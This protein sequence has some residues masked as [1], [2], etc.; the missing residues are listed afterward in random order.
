MQNTNLLKAKSSKLKAFTL[1]ELIIYIAMFAGA[2]IVLTSMLITILKVQ[3]REALGND[4][5]SQLTFVLENVNRLVR[6]SSLIEKVYEGNDLNAPCVNY[7]SVKLRMPKSSED[8]TIITSDED[9]IYLKRGST[10]PCAA[11][12]PNS[13]E[14]AI[15]NEKVVV[16]NLNFKQD[17]VQRGRSILNIDASLKFNSPD[18][19]FAIL[20]SIKSA[21]GRASAA[22]FDGSIVPIAVPP[23]TSDNQYDVG[24]AGNRWRDGFFG[25]NLIIGGISGV[26]IDEDTD[27][28]SGTSFYVPSTAGYFQFAKSGAGAPTATDCDQDNERGRLYIDTTNNRFYVCNGAT[29]NWDYAV[30]TN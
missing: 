15:T 14:C 6:E 9:A 3:N 28:P 17:V 10:G 26:G 11:T 19:K 18:P 5:S 21:V 29:R 27:I 20:R 22:A 24:V 25:R 12:A 30:L 13:L 2:S 7:C 4:V 23:A 16:T 8:P 1:I